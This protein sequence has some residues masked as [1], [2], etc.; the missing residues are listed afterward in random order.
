MNETGGVVGDIEPGQW[1][2]KLQLHLNMVVVYHPSS[3]IHY[4]WHSLWF[5]TCT[6][7][8]LIPCFYV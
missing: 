6:I 8:I 3:I 1:H 4:E 5:M 7:L 2:A